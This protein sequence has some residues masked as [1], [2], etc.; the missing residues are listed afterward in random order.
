MQGAYV[1]AYNLLDASADELLHRFR[2]TFVRTFDETI[3]SLRRASRHS[4]AEESTTLSLVEE[5]EFERDLAIGKLSARA[6]YYC[7]QQLTALTRRIAALL[8]L[9]SLEPDRNPLH[10]NTLFTAFVQ[11]GEA[12][13]YNRQAALALLQELERQTEDALP[14]LYGD[15]NRHLI[16][17][18][19]LPKL[20]LL[21]EQ[22][23]TR[24]RARTRSG[25]E[26]EASP[27]ASALAQAVFDELA[28]LL[29]NAG[30]ASASPAVSAAAPPA[31]ASPAMRAQMLAALTSIQTGA[32]GR[33]ALAR[34]GNRDLDP[35]AGVIL[36]PARQAEP[37]GRCDD[38]RHRRVA[39]RHLFQRQRG[40]AAGALGDRATAGPRAQGRAHGQGILLG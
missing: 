26:R 32:F 9:P 19:V 33:R 25:V 5:D 22:T 18:G 20:P 6:T 30:S 17:N 27:D 37:S 34:R 10:P 28:G 39:L 15:L 7:S 16:D 2:S 36:R 3:A 1:S 8:R 23:G 12:L 24:S 14:D 4:S 11:A 38:P 40:P 31:P 21:P 35:S 29:S 13:L